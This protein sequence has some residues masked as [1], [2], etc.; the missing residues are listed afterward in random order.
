ME[1]LLIWAIFCILIGVWANSYGRNGWL[2]GLIA[3][4]ISPLI[5]GVILLIVGKSI[6]KKAEELNKLS[7]LINK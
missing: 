1:I 3:A 6:E 4:I 7:S 2:W 5:T